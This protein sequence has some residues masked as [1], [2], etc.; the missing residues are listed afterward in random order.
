MECLQLDALNIADMVDITDAVDAVAAIQD[1]L[2]NAARK[3][4]STRCLT[5]QLQH[6]HL[7]LRVRQAMW[8][9]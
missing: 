7:Y 8:L 9:Q 3:S 6:L 4:P 5:V 1:V 2:S